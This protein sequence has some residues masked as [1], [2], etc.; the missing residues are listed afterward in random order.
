MADTFAHLCLVLLFTNEWCN[1]L[2]LLFL[3]LL[4][5]YLPLAKK[6]VLDSFKLKKLIKVNE[7]RKKHISV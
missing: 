2:F 6:K 3:L 7:K 1:C 5:I 4:C